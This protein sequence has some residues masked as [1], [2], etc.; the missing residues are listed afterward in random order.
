MTNPCRPKRSR[1]PSGGRRT[2]TAT[3]LSS[4]TTNYPAKR[5]KT[6]Q[7]RIVLEQKSPEKLMALRVNG[8]ARILPAPAVA[9]TV[10]VMSPRA[11][12]T[13]VT[14]TGMVGEAVIWPPLGSGVN[15]R[16][17][18]IRYPLRAV[19]TRRRTTRCDHHDGGWE[20]NRRPEGEVQR[21]TRLCRSGEPSD[22]NHCYQTEEMICLH[23]RFDEVFM[24][25]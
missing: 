3:H 9:V 1:A 17:R 25:S 18:A 24:G 12:A 20:Q 10:I 11:P 21:P 23:E 6:I 7:A 22:R 4:F 15:H 5:R 8:T 13:V 14:L 19:N 16:G 2:L